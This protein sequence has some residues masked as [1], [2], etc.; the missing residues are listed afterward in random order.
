M[1]A[2]IGITILFTII[3]WFCWFVFSDGDFT[4]QENRRNFIV[5]EI[6]LIASV[7]ACEFITD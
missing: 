4:P 6:C 7:I 2:L 1:K 3:N 5:S